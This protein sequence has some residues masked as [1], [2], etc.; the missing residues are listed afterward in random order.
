MTRFPAILSANCVLQ[1]GREGNVLETQKAPAQDRAGRRRRWRWIGI[2]F[3]S[4]IAIVV[5]LLIVVN[6]TPR[7]GAYLIKS[8]F[9]RN[10]EQNKDK[11]EQ[12]APSGIAVITNQQYRQGDGNAYLDVYFPE[13]TAANVKLPTLVWT[14]GGAWISGHKDD[15]ETY[16]K[17]IAAQGYT[18]VSLGYSLGPGHK[19]PTPI[20]QVNDALAYIQTNANDFHVDTARFMMAGDS[21]GAQI[22]SQYAALVTNPQFAS[23]V[24]ITPSITPAQLRGVILYCGIYDLDAFM[25]KGGVVSGFVGGLLQWGSHTSIWAYA[26][27]KDTNSTALTQMSS[28]N[29]A[30]AQ[31]PPTFISG[32]NGDPLTDHQSIPLAEKLQSLGV[33]VSSLF[34]PEDHEPS[35]AHEYQ[36]EL[37]LADAQTALTQMFAF[38]KERMV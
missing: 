37:N 29:H 33:P 7:P 30:T 31:F 13:S 9:E 34:Y 15:N 11:M 6:L 12:Y 17:L 21:A 22:T 27:T 38:M 26:G 20:F 8:V 24:G 18:V 32:G 4:L 14:H 10:A 35:L 3:G 23:E 16:F 36:F 5:V 1:P 19:Y 28:L 2:P 25:D